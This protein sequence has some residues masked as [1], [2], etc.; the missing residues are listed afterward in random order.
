LQ[1]ADPNIGVEMPTDFPTN[2]VG[3][4][5][6]RIAKEVGTGS[7]AWNEFAGGWNGMSYRLAAC[8]AASERFSGSLIEYGEA[9]PH[10]ERLVQEAALFEFIVSGL[11]SLECFT[12][13][14]HAIAWM[15]GSD[16]FAMRTDAQQRA[17]T[18]VSTTKRLADA[19][20]SAPIAASMRDLEGSE[21][22]AQWNVTRNF[23]AHRAAPRRLF[24]RNLGSNQPDPPAWWGNLT[25]TEGLT[26][27]RLA[28]LVGTLARLVLDTE[29][30]AAANSLSPPPRH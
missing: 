4:T 27:S 16:R 28:W 2:S 13:G 6:Q 20:P 17:V 11:S 5:T 7:A 14:L 30:F 1:N 29:T 21:D 18:I 23:I 10:A 9:P 19:F 8:A 3:R 15:T 26:P 24:F 12:Y 22:L 25:I